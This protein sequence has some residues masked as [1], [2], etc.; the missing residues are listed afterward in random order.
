MSHPRGRITAESVEEVSLEP[1][2]TEL[3]VTSR[4]MARAMRQDEITL[5]GHRYRERGE[6]SA[7]ARLCTGQQRVLSRA[8]KGEHR[9]KEDNQEF[10]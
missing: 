8:S 4:E 5:G 6:Q 9:R 1:R 3:G 7:R 2:D 10:V